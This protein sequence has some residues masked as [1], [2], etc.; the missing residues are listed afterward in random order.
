M[1][2]ESLYAVLR[3]RDG[4]S[5]LIEIS[6]VHDALA[7]PDDAFPPDFAIPCEVD[8]DPFPGALR[9]ERASELLKGRVLF[10]QRVQ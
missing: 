8:D 2:D 6:A 9:F 5:A 10:D 4:T 1:S 3:Y 7:V